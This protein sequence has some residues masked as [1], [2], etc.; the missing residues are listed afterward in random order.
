MCQV[1][2]KPKSKTSHFPEAY[3]AE[4]NVIGLKKKSTQAGP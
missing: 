4:K 1:L 2:T 3:K